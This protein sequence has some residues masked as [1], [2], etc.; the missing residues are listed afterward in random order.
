M[1]QFHR[2]CYLVAAF[3]VVSI[4]LSDRGGYQNL[5]H[6]DEKIAILRQQLSV[7]INNPYFWAEL[8]EL[9]FDR[10]R[11]WKLGGLFDSLECFTWAN[12]LIVAHGDDDAYHSAQFAMTLQRGTF[13]Y[14]SLLCNTSEPSHLKKMLF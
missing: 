9:Y 6:H 3:L 11:K 13:V 5:A 10:H 4:V 7:E 14:D 2:V 12:N 1:Q 8:G